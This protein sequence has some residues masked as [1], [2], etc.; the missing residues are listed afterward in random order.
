MYDGNDQPVEASARLRGFDTQT[1]AAPGRIALGDA[2]RDSRSAYFLGNG[3]LHYGHFL[4]EALSR[5]WAWEERGEDSVAIIRT[6][7]ISD[8][9]RSLCGLIPGLAERLEVLQATTRFDNVT[10]ASP[11]FATGR[12]AHVE[13]KAMCERMAERAVPSLE[14]MTEQP[15]YLSRA[16]LPSTTKRLVVGEERLERFLEREGFRVIRPETIA[17]ADQIALFNKHKW[18][19]APLG[20]ACHTKLF[21]RRPINLLVLTGKMGVGNPDKPFKTNYALCDL[22]SQGTVHYAKVFWVPDLGTELNLESDGPLMLD[23]ERLLALLRGFGL[24]RTTAVPEG[25]S[26]GLDDYK[27]KWMEYAEGKSVKG[28]T[29]RLMK[30][31]DSVDASLRR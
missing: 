23:E 3:A 27:A 9:A 13:F 20:S 24:V 14:P 30:A 7:P 10:V 5:A 29:R 15:L 2:R 26:P 16:G 1:S 25:R 4:L 19:V 6:P 17:V 22:L 8:F 12:A 31:I 18:I 11:A 28:A 21:S